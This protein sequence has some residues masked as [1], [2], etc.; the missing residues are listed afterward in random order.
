MPGKVAN[1]PGCDFSDYLVDPNALGEV[2]ECGEGPTTGS[3]QVE[4]VN[5]HTL[6]YTFTKGAIG[7]PSR[8]GIAGIVKG[9]GP[10]GVTFF[11]RGPDT[12]FFQHRLG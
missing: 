5:D 4:K 10:N 1:R 8:Y 7:K 11:D 2:E 12:G 6:R 3:A 9:A